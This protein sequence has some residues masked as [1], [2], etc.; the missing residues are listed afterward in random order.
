[1]L[2]VDD[3]LLELAEELPRLEQRL[4]RWELARLPAPCPRGIVAR[5]DLVLL[6]VL[7]NLAKLERAGEVAVVAE[8]LVHDL[9]GV[10]EERREEGLQ[11]VDRG[12]C[13]VE[14]R[15][16]ACAVRLDE[17]PRGL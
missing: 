15:R 3:G 9:G 14:H 4:A 10:R 13:D 12:K 1:E 2:F 16:R 17:R 11:A 7:V 5:Q 8:Q 6:A